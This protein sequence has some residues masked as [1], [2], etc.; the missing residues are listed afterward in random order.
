MGKEAI[1]IELSA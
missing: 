1:Y